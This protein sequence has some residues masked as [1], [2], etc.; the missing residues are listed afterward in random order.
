MLSGCLTVR[1]GNVAPVGD[2]TGKTGPINGGDPWAASGSALSLGVLGW[3][4]GL[5]VI[6]I[7]G[8][9]VEV[10]SVNSERV[11]I[12]ARFE[13][14]VKVLTLGGSVV[15]RGGVAVPEKDA[16]VIELKNALL[17]P[18]VGGGGDRAVV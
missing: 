17:D 4:D 6:V 10:T 12:T 8:E 15:P 11:V 3:K 7:L 1:D 16:G 9:A 18:P 2:V 14:S 5:V 13:L